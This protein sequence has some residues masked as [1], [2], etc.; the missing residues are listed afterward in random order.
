[1]QI[2]STTKLNINSEPFSID[3]GAQPYSNHRPFQFHVDG[4]DGQFKVRSF[5]LHD[6]PTSHGDTTHPHDTRFG[7]SQLINLVY[8]N[9]IVSL[10]DVELGAAD[11]VHVCSA[12]GVPAIGIPRHLQE[13]DLG[14]VGCTYSSSALESR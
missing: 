7:G 11:L 10:A 1:M 5:V 8:W 2:G 14:R 6:Q 12:A 9:V 13:A 3:C 4:A